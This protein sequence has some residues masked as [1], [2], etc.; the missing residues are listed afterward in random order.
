M[1]MDIRVLR[2]VPGRFKTLYP[3]F[4]IFVVYLLVNL[5]PI[6]FI[7]AQIFSCIPLYNLQ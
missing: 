5:F 1:V 2:K 3:S 4:D 7:R 6:N